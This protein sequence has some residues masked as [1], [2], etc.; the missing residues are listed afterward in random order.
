MK[1]NGRV[2]RHELKYYIGENDAILLRMLIQ[3]FMQVDENMENEEGYLVS[4]IYFDDMF[5]RAM[6][7]KLAGN[8]HRKKFR[9]RSYDLSDQLIRLECK[10]KFDQ[11]ISKRSAILSREEYDLIMHGEIDFLTKRREDVC[12]EFFAYCKTSLLHPVVV[13]EYLRE[14]YV[15]SAG[16]VRITFDKEV[17]ASLNTMD[18][19]SKDY[20]T[21]R[22]LDEGTIILEVKYDDFLPAYIKQLINIINTEQCAISKYVMCREYKRRVK[23]L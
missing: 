2:L 9:I 12:R 19:F 18:V 16:N 22:A 21:T 14:A 6:Q 17:S 5:H 1:Y 10:E 23:H 4:S 20:V 3:H 15:L 8:E 7:E 11:Y 13:V